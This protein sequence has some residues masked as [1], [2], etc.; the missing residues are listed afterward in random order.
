MIANRSPW[1]V[2]PDNNFSARSRLLVAIAS[3]FI[4]GCERSLRLRDPL[5]ELPHT[6]LSSAGSDKPSWAPVRFEDGDQDL[7]TMMSQSDIGLATSVATMAS[8]SC[9]SR[10]GGLNRTQLETLG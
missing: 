4:R 8:S 9:W 1:P 3:E 2:D 7:T 5:R 6:L 10:S